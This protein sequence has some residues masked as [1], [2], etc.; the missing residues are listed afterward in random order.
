M[1]DWGNELKDNWAS[2]ATFEALVTEGRNLL[3]GGDSIR[4]HAAIHCWDGT[5]RA[6]SA[7]GSRAVLVPA[8][9]L[10]RSRVAVLF[11]EGGELPSDYE[12]W[13]IPI[14]QASGWK[15]RLGR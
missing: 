4:T 12:V 5:L 6:G 11:L 13:C 14:D 1:P 3:R 15:L 9:R 8:S 2:P 7:S 10:E